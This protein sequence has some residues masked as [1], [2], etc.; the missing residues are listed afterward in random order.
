MM[1]CNNW[2]TQQ[3]RLQI[4]TS[5]QSD[6]IYTQKSAVSSGEQCDEMCPSCHVKF[7]IFTT[8]GK[9]QVANSWKRD[10]HPPPIFILAQYGTN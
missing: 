9:V 5:T 1:D 6:D 8:N 3:S 2:T 7:L 4:S 10:N